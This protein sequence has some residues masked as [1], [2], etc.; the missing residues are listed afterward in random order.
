MSGS[1]S[2]GPPALAAGAFARPGP[3]RRLLPLAQWGLAAGLLPRAA[4]PGA[5]S[6]RSAAR[7]GPREHEQTLD[8]LPPTL[9][10]AVPSL[11]G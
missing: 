8:A 11:A 6:P 7:A 2:P 9:E 5:V 3:P 4:R 10:T 1:G